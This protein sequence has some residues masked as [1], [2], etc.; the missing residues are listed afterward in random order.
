MWRNI[1]LIISSV[2]FLI[3]TFNN[4]FLER[5]VVLFDSKIKKI[6]SENEFLNDDISQILDN[7]ELTIKFDNFTL[8][9]NLLLYTTKNDTVVINDLLTKRGKLVFYYS[10]QYCD[11]CYKNLLKQVNNFITYSGTKNIIVL[12]EYKNLR[13]FHY[14]LKDNEIKAEI[15]L[16]SVNIGFPDQTIKQPFFFMIDQSL[17]VKYFYAPYKKYLRNVNKYLSIVDDYLNKK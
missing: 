14:F 17:K 8:N 10:D 15:Y 12:A 4:Y 1:L 2:L 13:D 7:E 5:K 16:I 9:P 11:M 6:V 3:V